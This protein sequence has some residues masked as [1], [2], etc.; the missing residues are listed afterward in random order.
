MRAVQAAPAV[1][2]AQGGAW[3][4][5]NDQLRV[6]V[7]PAAGQVSVLDRTRRR[8]WREPADSRVL[9]A[10]IRPVVRAGGAAIAFDSDRGQNLSLFLADNS[11]DLAVTTDMPDRSRRIAPLDG[12]PPFV[13]A[14]AAGVIAASDYCDGHIYPVDL[15]A[16]PLGTSAGGRMDDMPW[17]GVCDLSAGYGYAMI[18]DTA[19]DAR[20][21]YHTAVVD[22]RKIVAPAPVWLPS[23]QCFSY[24]RTVIYSFAASGGYVALAKAY[25]AY[26]L[27]R[28]L[29]NPL[30]EKLKR[31]PNVARL[32]GAPDVWGDAT[33]DFARQA[34]VLGV[35]RM[36]IHGR[37]RPE[38]MKAI[39]D[40]GFLTS[41]YDDYDD[42]EPTDA[43]HGVDSHHDL[44]P[45]HAAMRADGVRMTAWLTWDKKTQFMKRCPS[46]WV[47]AAR[48]VVPPILQQYPYLGRFI[49]V[50]TAEDPFECYD[51]QHP[52]TRSQM[53]QCGVD[54]AAYME[55]QGLVAG[56]EHG[57]WWAP[58]HE[59]YVEGMMSGNRTSWPAGYLIHPDAKDQSFTDP[60]GRTL[61]SWDQYAS[62]SMGQQYRVPLF[63]LVFHDCIVTTWYWGD[64]S[65]FLLKAAP[66][67]TAKKDAYNV[68]Y[69]TI[70]LLWANKSGS[71]Q[72]DRELFLRTYRNTCK[73]HEAVAGEQMLDH[74]FVTPDRD[75]QATAFSGGTRAIVNFGATPYRATLDGRHYLLPQNGWVAIGPKI[76]QSL[77][78]EDGK[79]VTDIEAPGYRYC[80]RGG[81]GVNV[82][83]EG[84]DRLWINAGASEAAID[85][86]PAAA[87]PGWDRKSTRLYALDALGNRGG[88]LPLVW[89]GKN[90]L[91][92]PAAAQSRAF[93]LV[94]RAGGQS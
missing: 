36:L 23:M 70:P 30:S 18:L 12:L 4:L 13:L 89:A 8:E 46:F 34:H 29:I 51:P 28:G 65:D 53:R 17:V 37:A 73:M 66:E 79:I 21:R 92:L 7:D 41:E 16:F 62:L 32:F 64:S 78:L 19:D 86:D 45:D 3:I 83:R 94:C 11:R 2:F 38:D 6:Q 74:E 44:L 42:I 25:R 63:E 90:K 85:V 67:M 20:V 26:A 81:V 48:R 1:A 5:Q 61:P 54:L 22:G 68:L 14:S 75:V 87:E 55:S 56:G 59:D 84:T 33:L 10:N 82:R 77:A 39:D 71:W 72:M 91:R 27:Q 80:D 88:E 49:D 57:K 69:G 15:D 76:R 60:H 31:N 50:V 40:L 52:L 93:E 35:D 9:L 58:Q 47:D 24:P 43:A